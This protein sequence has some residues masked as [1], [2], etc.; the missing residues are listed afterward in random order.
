[1]IICPSGTTAPFPNPLEIGNLLLTKSLEHLQPVDTSQ[2]RSVVAISILL[3]EKKGSTLTTVARR[4]LTLRSPL[5]HLE[6]LAV[7]DGRC[8]WLAIEN[9]LP[10]EEIDRNVDDVTRP[11]HVAL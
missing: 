11:E 7:H 2:K 10:V 9:L 6:G 3:A 5:Y 8:H 4:G 1:M